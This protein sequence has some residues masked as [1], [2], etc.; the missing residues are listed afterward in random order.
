MDKNLDYYFV[1]RFHP[2]HEF[3]LQIPCSQWKSG[4]AASSDFQGKGWSAC[5]SVSVWGR[6]SGI[7]VLITSL[8]RARTEGW[9]SAKRL[10]TSAVVVHQIKRSQRG[11]VLLADICLQTSHPTHL[12]WSSFHPDPPNEAPFPK[13]WSTKWSRT[14]VSSAWSPL[15]S[16]TP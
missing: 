9:W 1:R 2:E 3:I 13:A 5:I 12:W 4:A 10:W 7:W 15:Y 11:F 6:L 14:W 16:S 8:S